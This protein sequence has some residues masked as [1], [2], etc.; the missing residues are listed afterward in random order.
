[1][2]TRGIAPQ[3]V[4]SAV[5]C[6]RRLAP[7]AQRAPV[8][9]PL[10]PWARPTAVEWAGARVGASFGSRSPDR[11]AGLPNLLTLPAIACLSIVLQQWL[12][13]AALESA[14]AITCCPSLH[15]KP[16]IVLLQGHVTRIAFRSLRCKPP[17]ASRLLPSARRNPRLQGHVRRSGSACGPQRASSVPDQQRRHQTRILCVGPLAPRQAGASPQAG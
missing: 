6:C 14:A 1:M 8:Q 10:A 12:A 5:R 2:S 11:R 9:V 17:T 4:R 3:R 13:G 16:Q 15:A 7:C